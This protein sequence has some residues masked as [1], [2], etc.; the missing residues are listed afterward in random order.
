VDEPAA[1]VDKADGRN[2]KTKRRFHIIAHS[3]THISPTGVFLTVTTTFS[4]FFSKNR[5]NILTLGG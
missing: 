4:V 3:F 1:H 5:N 2:V